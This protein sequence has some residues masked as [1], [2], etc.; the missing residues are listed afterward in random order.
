M[1]INRIEKNHNNYEKIKPKENVDFVAYEISLKDKNNNK[2]QPNGKLKVRI[3]CKNDYDGRKCRV[4]YVTPEGKYVEMKAEYSGGFV[5]FETTHF[6]TYILTSEKLAVGVE[7]MFTYGDINDDGSID[8]KDA[9][10][11]KKYLA[12][13]TGLDINP[14]ACDVNA[15]G[16]ITSADAVLLL[17]KLAGYNVTLGK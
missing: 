13:Y 16:D 15:D 10:L 4:Y 9:V 12:G 14:D 6:S 8:T 5:V 2:V 7:T 1:R 3:P 17:K 11:I